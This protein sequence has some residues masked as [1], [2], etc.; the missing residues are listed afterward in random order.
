M[1]SSFLKTALAAPLVLWYRAAAYPLKVWRRISSF[2]A[3]RARLTLPVPVST[4]VLGRANV[5]GSGRVRCGEGLLLY[6]RL[7]LE[8]HGDGEIVLG[9]GVVLSTGVH[10]VAYAGIY[11]GRGTM[12]GEYTSVR[13]ANHT[14]EHG[15]TLRDSDHTAKPIVIGS[16]VW[17]G[18]GVTVLGGVTIGDR[19]IVG[20]NAVVT[21]DVP[22]DA[23]VAGVPAV[24]IKYRV[25]VSSEIER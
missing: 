12:I 13:D 22:A 17:I 23:V 9:D 20:A 21:R 11:V 18:R 2:A 16:E 4:V 8:T 24:P 6:P 5:Y 19:A 14:R 15:R 3:L 25:P 10:L 1:Y 7:Y